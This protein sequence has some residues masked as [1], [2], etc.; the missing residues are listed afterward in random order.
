MIIILACYWQKLRERRL[1]R[2]F[3]R[4]DGRGRFKGGM[5]ALAKELGTVDVLAPP[6]HPGGLWTVRCAWGNAKIH[7]IPT[8]EILKTESARV[9]GGYE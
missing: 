5:M 8:R 7:Y 6:F 2:Q 4:L 1:I 3:N 9:F